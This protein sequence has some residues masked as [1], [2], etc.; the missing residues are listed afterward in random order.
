MAF[1]K[2]TKQWPYTDIICVGVSVDSTPYLYGKETYHENVHGFHTIHLKRKD[3]RLHKTGDILTWDCSDIF[4]SICNY[5][6]VGNNTLIVVNHSLV[7]LGS[8]DFTEQMEA[9]NILLHRGTI[10][11]EQIH[12][13]GDEIHDTQSFVCSCPP[14]VVMFTY[15]HSGKRYTMVD[16]NNYGVKYLWDTFDKFTDED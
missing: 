1:T 4:N 5:L 7:V 13:R 10:G 14:T 11:D 15:T 8:S 9:G 16:V 12:G 6:P 3:K 2:L